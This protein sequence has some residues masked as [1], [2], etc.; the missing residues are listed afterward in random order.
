MLLFGVLL[1]H[2]L[3]IWLADK[4]EDADEIF[5]QQLEKI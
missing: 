1:I 2:K 4:F 3:L 5:G